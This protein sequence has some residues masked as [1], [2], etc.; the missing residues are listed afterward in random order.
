MPTSIL[1]VSIYIPTCIDKSSTYATSSPGFLILV[2]LESVRRYPI[3]ILI[4]ISLMTN[5]FEY[6]SIYCRTAFYKVSLNVLAIF[7]S[8]CIFLNWILYWITGLLNIFTELFLI[9]E[10]F[11]RHLHCKYSPEVACLFIILMVFFHEQKCFCFSL[12]GYFLN[13]I[14]EIFVDLKIICPVFL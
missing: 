12:S 2:I 5:K 8:L 10:S 1:V 4:C 3:V 6:L 13:S 7:I 9:H 14:C 11:V